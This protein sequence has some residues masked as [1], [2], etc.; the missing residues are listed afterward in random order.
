MRIQNHVRL[1]SVLLTGL[2]GAGLLTVGFG[3]TPLSGSV[4]GPMLGLGSKGD[5][6]LSSNSPVTMTRGQTGTISVTVTSMNHLSG[7][8]SVTA[9]LVTSSATPPAVSTSQSSAKL[10][11]DD[12]ASFSVTVKT[13]SSTSLGFYNIT[14]QGK[15]GSLSH[16]TTLSVDVT[17]PPPPP[18]PDFSLSSSSSSLTVTR[19]SYAVGTLTVSSIIGYSGTIALSVAL[20]PLL[21]NPPIVSLN[22]TSLKLPSRGTNSTTIIVTAPNAT[23][24]YY[25][26][27]VTGI[28]GSLSHLLNIPLTVNSTVPSEALNF[29]SYSID[30]T[31]QLTLTIMNFGNVNTRFVSYYVVDA[32]N[33]R[34]SLTSWNGPTINQGQTGT[35]TILIGSSCTG[36][37]LSGAP[38]NFVNGNNYRIILVTALNNQ[39]TLTIGQTTGQE[40]LTFD[41]YAFSSSTNLTLYLRNT[42]TAQVQLSAYSVRD[43]NGDSYSLTNL[44]G[45]TIAVNQVVAVTF[46]IGSSCP[47]CTLSGSPFV[48]NAGYSYSIIITTSRN[49][50]FTFTVTR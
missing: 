2:A 12:T 44:A 11:P 18:S 5:F 4:L 20:Y 26:I 24:G 21:S 17:Q 40:Q 9:A 38:F 22:L 30:S 37:V 16:S 35:V 31:T 25:T 8:V 15:I 14:V 28:S 3:L 34:Y 42:G 49:N 43:A 46:T 1:V 27:I 47:S 19:G 48:F 6:S 50:M 13:T 32:N 29:Q 36:C 45:P 7:Y 41:S 23:I 10:N 39:F 33:D